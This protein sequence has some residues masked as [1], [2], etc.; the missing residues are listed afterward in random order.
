MDKY[1]RDKNIQRKI[2]DE[3]DMR[4]KHLPECD[5]RL[6]NR[7]VVLVSRVNSTVGTSKACSRDHDKYPC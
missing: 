3:L 4:N 1:L 6:L 2:R 5:R 7:Q